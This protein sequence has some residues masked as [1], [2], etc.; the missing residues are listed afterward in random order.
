MSTGQFLF[1]LMFFFF[2]HK[3]RLL[4][5]WN[6]TAKVWFTIYCKYSFPYYIAAQL[7][8]YVIP[9]IIK[10]RTGQFERAKRNKFNIAT[11]LI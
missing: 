11:F 2:S 7:T 10:T 9:Y 1:F 5:P 3:Y 6:A 8:F 4:Q